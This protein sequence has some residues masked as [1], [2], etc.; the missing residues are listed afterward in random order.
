VVA[1]YSRSMRARRDRKLGATHST[2]LL[3]RLFSTAAIVYTAAEP[4]DLL[5]SRQMRLLSEKATLDLR[6]PTGEEEDIPPE[7]ASPVV[8]FATRTIYPTPISTARV[9]NHTLLQEFARAAR[10]LR[11]EFLN[12]TDST[13]DSFSNDD[14]FLWQMRRRRG[15]W[16]D[17]LRQQ[18]EGNVDD[19]AD[20]DPRRIVLEQLEG[21]VRGACERHVLAGES[22][23]AAV[24]DFASGLA[25][26]GGAGYPWGHDDSEEEATYRKHLESRDLLLWSAIH[27]SSSGR[28]HNLHMHNGLC[29]GVLYVEMPVGA[30]QLEFTDPRHARTRLRLFQESAMGL[31]QAENDRRI[32]AEARA[33]GS[34][35]QLPPSNREVK[36]WRQ[37]RAVG[38]CSFQD[39]LTCF[40]NVEA[41]QTDE[42]S[43]PAGPFHTQVRLHAST[44]DLVLFPTWLAHEVPADWGSNAAPGE[45]RIVFSFNLDFGNRPPRRY[46][47][48]SKLEAQTTLSATQHNME[49]KEKAELP[50][51]D[52]VLVLKVDSGSPAANAGFRRWDVIQQIDEQPVVTASG[53]RAALENSSAGQALSVVVVRKKKKRKGVKMLELMLTPFTISLSP[54]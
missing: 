31:T 50:E 54:I 42:L 26:R 40:P 14:F 2:L 17:Q 32:H 37:S 29:A 23:S 48:L 30:P 49:A 4:A 41:S 53:V 13:Y 19:N 15:Q 47:G 24:G 45:E 16:A 6:R 46:S 3:L 8:D 35:K 27:T 11:A 43:A 18:S 21:L 25:A 51:A 9:G 1:S 5:T 39:P 36:A 22:T 44:G 38:G 28:G 7:D 20:V 10:S 34:V 12:S 52:G 33:D